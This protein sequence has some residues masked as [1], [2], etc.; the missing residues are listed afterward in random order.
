[1]GDDS[2]SSVGGSASDSDEGF[3][4][5][6]LGP[7]SLV[8]RDRSSPPIAPLPSA[9]PPSADSQELAMLDTKYSSTGVRSAAMEAHQWIAD[10]RAA[11]KFRESMPP[12]VARQLILD[13]SFQPGVRPRAFSRENGSWIFKEST[14][15]AETIRTFRHNTDHAE[16]NTPPPD[17]WHSSGGR[18]SSRDL[19]AP[20]PLIRRRYGSIERAK[21]PIY[22]YHEYSIISPKSDEYSIISP[23]SEKSDEKNEGL[24]VDGEI[25]ED[26][27]IILF[28]VV[29]RRGSSGSHMAQQAAAMEASERLIETKRAA[30]AKKSAATECKSPSPSCASAVAIKVEKKSVEENT[31]TRTKRPSSSGS[32]GAKRQ[33][34]SKGK[35]IVASKARK[36]AAAAVGGAKVWE[37]DKY[38]EIKPSASTAKEAQ[39][40]GAVLKLHAPANSGGREE[41]M[42]FHRGTA[43]QGYIMDM[44]QGVKLL[45]T[46]GDFAEYHRIRD[47]E[48]PDTFEEGEIVGLVDGE[49]TRST[50][51]AAMLGIISRKAVVEGSHP[52]FDDEESASRYDTVAYCGRV[53]VKLRGNAKSGDLVV[54]SGLND[55]T[56]V[57]VRANGSSMLPPDARVVAIV[58]KAHQAIRAESCPQEQVVSLVDVA[59]TG[60]AGQRLASGPS[61][62]CSDGHSRFFFVLLF[63]LAL[64]GLFVGL[65][66][67]IL[68]DDKAERSVAAAEQS[69]LL[70]KQDA[71]WDAAQQQV[72][73]EVPRCGERAVGL[74]SDICG[75][76]RQRGRW[77]DG[78][79]RS[80][81]AFDNAAF[82]AE[83]RRGGHL[84]AALCQR[85]VTLLLK[86]C[87]DPRTFGAIA[88][89]LGQPSEV[90]F[91]QTIS[92]LPQVAG[93][94][95]EVLDALAVLALWERPRDSAA[96]T[97]DS[98]MY[99]SMELG[100]GQDRHADG[101]V[102]EQIVGM[103]P[104][105]IW[106]HLF[107]FDALE[108]VS[109]AVPASASNRG[110]NLVQR[111]T[112][113]AYCA[114][115]MHGMLTQCRTC[116]GHNNAGDR[117]A[118]V[119]TTADIWNSAA[120]A[121]GG[122]MATCDFDSDAVQH[123]ASSSR[124]ETSASLRVRLPEVDGNV[125]A[126]DDG[127]FSLALDRLFCSDQILLRIQSETHIEPPLLTTAT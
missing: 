31:R 47:G 45:S 48:R 53:P 20:N 19:P 95:L 111:A 125:E 23:K 46:A 70:H 74:L 123:G 35:G 102:A 113:Q 64:L 85:T 120:A 119:A 63:V 116:Y 32:S 90:C 78:V 110:T 86:H 66:V 67:A 50:I 118:C 10:T 55:G 97:A 57:A 126:N 54:P 109:F 71:A 22:A 68:S 73:T 11:G 33:T 104:P 16:E 30:A 60:P 77:T 122:Q 75:F 3:L 117:K 101:T 58:E 4:W 24:V 25:V 51:G 98:A 59:V 108:G 106:D 39:D 81:T 26:R 49:I 17:R 5:E 93:T 1:M 69:S 124:V 127:S 103:T 44:G 72:E 91:A 62:G 89:P 2:S 40:H 65:L 96:S 29:E 112:T 15:M 87:V 43:V 37:M 88:A 83:T 121:R 107:D 92:S 94:K 52:G 41:Y 80:N 82:D 99:C 84:P 76:S 14:V 34:I 100:A 79:F 38:M 7:S 9:P 42:S 6:E 21:V 18:K 115:V 28:H 27:R 61:W 56:A 36:I 13:T 114:Q 8:G 12:H 105:S